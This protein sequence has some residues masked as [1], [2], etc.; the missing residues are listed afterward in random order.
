MRITIGNVEYEFDAE[1]AKENGWLKPVLGKYKSFS[2]Y[3]AFTYKNTGATVSFIKDAYNNYHMSGCFRNIFNLYNHPS[4]KDEN[5][6]VDYINS[7]AYVFCGRVKITDAPNPFL[8][9]E[10]QVNGTVYNLN[11]SKA[12]KHECVSLKSTERI[13]VVEAGDQFTLWERKLEHTGLYDTI[14][15]VDVPS[16]FRFSGTST[17]AFKTYLGEWTSLR[18]VLTFLNDNNYIKIGKAKV[19]IIP[20]V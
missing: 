8:N 1:R 5:A 7:N 16:G 4:F 10:V 3:D 15:A 14:T 19:E 2:L 17:N 12:I 18:A 9:Q 11:L 20:A 6:V 13:S